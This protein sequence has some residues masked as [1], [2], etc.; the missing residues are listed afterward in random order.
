MVGGG[1]GEGGKTIRHAGE[2][3]R[4]MGKDYLE[5]GTKNLKNY[6][7]FAAANRSNRRSARTERM[8]VRSGHQAKRLDAVEGRM[9][10]RNENRAN[11]RANY[12]GMYKDYYDAVLSN[13]HDRRREGLVAKIV[14]DRK[15]ARRARTERLDRKLTAIYGR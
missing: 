9:V 10:R 4:G 15:D 8:E 2:T 7:D 11:R 12:R 6:E 1:I 5:A 13:E 3:L 14:E